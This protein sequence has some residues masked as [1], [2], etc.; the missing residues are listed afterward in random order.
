MHKVGLQPYCTVMVGSWGEEGMSEPTVCGEQPLLFQCLGFV[1][2]P[3][4][5]VIQEKQL[6]GERVC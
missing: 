1:S 2:C 6:K 3:S 5:K 4:D